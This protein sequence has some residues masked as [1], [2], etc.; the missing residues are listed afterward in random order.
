MKKLLSIILCVIMLFALSSCG[1]VRKVESLTW[2][3]SNYNIKNYEKNRTE[4]EYADKFMPS[5]DD[6][7]GYTNIGYSY[8]YTNQ[9]MFEIYSIALYVEYP[10]DIYEEKKIEVLSS[11]DFLEETRISKDGESY[12]SPAARFEYGGYS[13]STSINT[14]V[15]YYDNSYCKS[16]AFIGVND[17]KHRIAYCYTYDFHLD[18]FGSIDRFESEQEMITQYIDKF[19]DWKD[20][21]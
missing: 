20:L 21:P 6:L 16:F 5:L 17:D 11:Y 14:H 18:T 15:G 7:D 9:M 19:Y 10:A 3:F 12:Q 13:F 2:G 1:R 8:Q 4:I